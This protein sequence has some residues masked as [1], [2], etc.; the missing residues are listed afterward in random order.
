MNNIK[1]VFS[2]L[3]SL[4]SDLEKLGAQ[5][6]LVG[7]CVR[8]TLLQQKGHK[9]SFKDVDIEV[10]GIEMEILMSVLSQHSG[11]IDIVG[12][13]FGIIKVMMPGF[14]DSFP[15]IEALDIS[16][17]RTEQKTGEGHKSFEV[18]VDPF[19]G[20]QQASA[21]RDYTINSMMMDIEGIRDPF[22]GL[23]HLSKNMLVATSYQFAEDPLRVLRGMGQAGR[24]HLSVDEST[25]ALCCSL[26]HEYAHLSK[27][28]IWGEWWKWATK[29]TKPSLGLNFL[30]DTGWIEF[31][32]E[33]ESLVGVPQDPTWHPEGDVWVHTGFV[34]DAAA[35]IAV[36]EGLSSFDRGVL[37]MAALCH[38]LAKPS[39]TE[40]QEDGRI[41]SR[42]HEKA[43]E[44]PTISLFEKMGYIAPKKG[45]GPILETVIPLV[46]NHLAHCSMGAGP[47][48]K[49][50]RKLSTKV[51]IERLALLV[52]AD[53]S[54]RPPLPKEMPAGM[55]KILQMSKEMGV[56]QGQPDPLIT[57]KVLMSA[58]VKPGK[59]MGDLIHKAFDGQ[60]DGSFSTVE[61]GL[62]WLG[63]S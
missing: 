44:E 11:S 60:L 39:C 41:T 6:Y 38:D 46:V 3:S 32:P 7:G 48:A 19:L 49:A 51:N 61:Q 63:L 17:P 36:R 33:L 16:L 56:S 30:K 50:V 35:E 22:G 2:S 25:A 40:T 27:E 54:G 18:S 58:G 20:L 42:G 9:V 21:R 8:D 15:W 23:I 26:K 10:H 57:G 1:N 5:P 62:M 55:S 31:Y 59:D 24:F 43:G 29:S 37:V 28:R 52:E 4:F 34:C 12:K 53:H 47:S 13:S 14:H 45:H